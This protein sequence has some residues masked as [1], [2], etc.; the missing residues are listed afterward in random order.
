MP[1]KIRGSQVK[2]DTLTG[3]DINEDT[4]LLKYFTTHKYTLTSSS[5]SLFVRFNAAGSNTSGGVNNRFVAPA[6]G[7]LKYVVYRTDGTPGNT[8][9]AFCKITDGTGTFGSGSPSADVVQNVS[10][11]NTSYIFDF[12]SLNSP[13]DTTFAAGNVLGIRINPTNNHGNADLTVVWEFDWS[14]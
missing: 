5:D 2:D 8:E 9:I 6:S 12:S 1:T 14:T 7:K 3:D 13:H 11:S 4:L 10:S